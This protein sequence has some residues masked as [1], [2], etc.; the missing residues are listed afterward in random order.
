MI[1]LDGCAVGETP[2]F[3]SIVKEKEGIADVLFE[4]W[5]PADT[6][7]WLREFFTPF[8]WDGDEDGEGDGSEQ[9]D[10]PSE[11]EYLGENVH[12]LHVKQGQDA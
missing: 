5:H 6:D 10:R 1:K 12:T 7:A 8:V 3:A 11:P 2:T 9:M 4:D